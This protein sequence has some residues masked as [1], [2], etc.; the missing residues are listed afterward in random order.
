MQ[1]IAFNSVAAG[2]PCVCVRACVC[3]CVHSVAPQMYKPMAD[4][5]DVT[6]GPLT[7]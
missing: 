1:G 4:T 6:T 7:S 2:I 5:L 3:V